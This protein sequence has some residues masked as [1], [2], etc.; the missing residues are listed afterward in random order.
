M[1]DVKNDLILRGKVSAFSTMIAAI[2]G[3]APQVE[4][5]PEYVQVSFSATQKKTLQDLFESNLRA[6]PGVFRIDYNSVT[7]PPLFR[8]YG[9]YAIMLLFAAFLLGKI[10]SK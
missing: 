2:T 9:K 10:S 6:K 5:F 8:V 1:A 4:Y 7:L 3:E